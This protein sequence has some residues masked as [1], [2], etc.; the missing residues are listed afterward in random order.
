MGAMQTSSSLSLIAVAGATALA[1]AIPSVAPRLADPFVPSPAAVSTPAPATDDSDDSDATDASTARTTA[2][3]AS[4]TGTV[5]AA[6]SKGVVLI[7]AQTSSGEAAGTGMVLSSSGQVLTNYHVVEGSTAI[8]VTV[9]DTGDTYEATVVGH[10]ASRDVALL[11][12]ADASGLATI[13]PDADAVA[14]GDALT[15][16]GNASGE[17]ELVAASGTVTGLDEE[18]TVSSDGSARTLTGVIETTAGA[19]PGDSGGP[20][21]DQEGEVSG[22]TS[23]GSQSVAAAP[24]RGRGRRERPVTSVS[25]AVPIR[26]ALAVVEQI[27]SG[28]ESGTVQVGARAYL[29]IS[30]AASSSLVVSSVIEDGPAAGV[31]VVAGSLIT[32][33]DGVAVTTHDELA[34]ELEGLDP[35]ERVTLAWTDGDG[36]RHTGT[37]TL[38]ESPVN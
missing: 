38:A 8:G 20:M 16:V 26:T 15:A 35:G 13:T 7:A 9:A 36:V 23:A 11:Q 1:L 6:Q 33:I 19:V 18:V 2:G 28:R 12:L 5:T 25:Y 37:V 17:G 3:T 27:R 4:L 21:Y 29:G 10:D 30:V 22:M 14:L 24:A 31:G 32:A 34:A